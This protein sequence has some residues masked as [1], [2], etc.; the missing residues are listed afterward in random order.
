MALFTIFLELEGG[1]YLSQVTAH[2]E[3]AALS[4]WLRTVPTELS[5]TLG[6]AVLAALRKEA[7]RNRDLTP[8]DGLVG[9]WSRTA[10]VD[11]SLALVHIVRTADGERPGT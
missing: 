10:L 8:I 11:D 3:H 1:S 6:P 5:L 7:R 4:V 2:D 9:V